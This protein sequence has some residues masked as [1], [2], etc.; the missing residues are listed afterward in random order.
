MSVA[1]DETLAEETGLR[2]LAGQPLYQKIAADLRSRIREQEF[3]AGTYLP[4]EEKLCAHY[5]VSRFTIREALRQL[6]VEGLIARRRGAGTLIQHEQAAAQPSEAPQ[7][8]RAEAEQFISGRFGGAT[9]LLADDRL[10]QR[11]GCA[12]GSRW[13]VRSTVTTSV[14]GIPTG[15]IEFYLGMPLKSIADRLHPGSGPIWEQLHELGHPVAPVKMRIQS[16]T[17]VQTEARLLNIAALSP[18]LRITY[19]C[20]SAEGEPLAIA[21]H[22]HP[23][24]SFAYESSLNSCLND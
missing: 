23:G 9:S 20:H 13:L 2:Q 22:L 10:A 8:P 18:C 24:H 15:L 3:A 7:S 14:S 1:V 12:P 19:T 21:T 4:T 6:Q 11:L 17:P 5:R 16:V